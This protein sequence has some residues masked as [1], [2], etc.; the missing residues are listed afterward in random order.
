MHT[1]T[2]KLFF[3]ALLIV[4]LL[5]VVWIGGFAMEFYRFELGSLLTNAV[6]WPAALAFYV[7]FAAALIIFVIEPA[8]KAKSLRKALILGA[9]F[10]FATYMTYDLTNLA[11]TKD[12]SLLIAVVD[13]VWGTVLTATASVCTYLLATRV[14]KL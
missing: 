3:T 6:V 1:R 5:D 4:F 7:F 12:W 8:L 11:T 2:L 10:G 14:Y 9:L 13:M